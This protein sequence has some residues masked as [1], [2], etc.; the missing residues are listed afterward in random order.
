[1]GSC[2]RS[3]L[4]VPLNLLLD[5]R[6]LLHNRL[7]GKKL[8]GAVVPCVGRGDAWER[9]SYAQLGKETLVRG[10]SMRSW[11]RS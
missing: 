8:G 1:M 11:K 9:L 6:T 7:G 3:S 2:S 5:G 4:G 10:C